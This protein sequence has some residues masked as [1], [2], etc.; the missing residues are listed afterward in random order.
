MPEKISQYGSKRHKINAY[1]KKVVIYS[2][3]VFESIFEIAI[4]NLQNEENE[5][6][7]QFDLYFKA[8]IWSKIKGLNIGV[9]VNYHQP[10]M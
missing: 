2:Y 8:F 9:I 3:L 5:T 6:R 1:Q 7:R 10:T 4:E